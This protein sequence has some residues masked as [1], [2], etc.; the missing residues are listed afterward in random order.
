MNWK[1]EDQNSIRKKDSQTSSFKS[2]NKEE[3]KSSD[4]EF[5]AKITN[6]NCSKIHSKL[7]LEENE[8]KH[9]LQDNNSIV[10]INKLND[11]D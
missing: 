7:Q 4:Q 9:D 5:T 6:L 3:L 1:Q 11:I 8:V 2:L 10:I